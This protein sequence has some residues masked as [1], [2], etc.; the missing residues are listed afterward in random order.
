M[1]SDG[2]AT[3]WALD[4]YAGL[5]ARHPSVIAGVLY[6]DFRRKHDDVTVLIA[7]EK[8]PGRGQSPP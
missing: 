6:R 8:E 7:R 5:T 2:L 3:Q 1:H 4:R